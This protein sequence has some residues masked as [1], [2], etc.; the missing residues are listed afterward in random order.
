MCEV[1]PIGALRQRAERLE[2]DLQLGVAR[3]DGRQLMMRVDTRAAVAGHVL[4][5]ADDAARAPAPRA[6]RGPARR[7]ASARC[8]RRGSRSRR[9]CRAATTSSSGAQ[10]TVMPTSASISPSACAVG[11]R[12]LDRRHRRDVVQRVERRPGGKRG[13]FGRP[14]PRDAARPPGRSGSAGRRARPASRSESVSA[15]TCARSTTLRLNRM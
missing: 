15:R 2:I 14:H 4:D 5:H 6:S 9:S 12:R 1:M 10:S 13:P 7:R 8:H 3:G 11:A